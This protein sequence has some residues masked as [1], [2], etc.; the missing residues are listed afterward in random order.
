MK[1]NQEDEQGAG[2]RAGGD[3]V[4]KGPSK[5]SEENAESGK[6]AGGDVVVKGASQSPDED[7]RAEGDVDKGGS[8]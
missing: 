7:S 8:Q 5:E 3:V 4:V 1:S 6:R 2:T